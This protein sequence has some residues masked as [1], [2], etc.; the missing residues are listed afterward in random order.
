MLLADEPFEPRIVGAHELA[1]GH[2]FDLWSETFEYGE[3]AHGSPV[4]ISRE[5][6]R[7]P[8]AVA[9]LALDDDDRVCVIQQYRH[10]V[11]ARLWELPA[12]LLDVESEHPLDA[13]KREFAEEVD[14]VAAE[15]SLL[16]EFAT[17]AGGST[18]AVR[19]FLARG[20]S[21]SPEPFSR[22]DE[23]A[24]MRMAWVPL[25]DVADAV[26]ARRVQN[27]ILQVGVLSAV[28]SRARGWS[29]LADPDLPWPGRRG[30]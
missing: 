11:R 30:R 5:L 22:V 2:V 26:L 4:R 6:L 20:L 24:D 18:E 9:V 13:A 23:E 16:Q 28:A 14:L 12:G 25:D 3:D 10:P 17:S 8:G 1:H 21:D 7:H 15:W 27:S 19:V 29:T